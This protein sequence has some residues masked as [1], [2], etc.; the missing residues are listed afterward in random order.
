MLGAVFGKLF[1][2][3]NLSAILELAPSRLHMT[4]LRLSL[5]RYAE[6]EL[7][8]ITEI[9]FPLRSET[10]QPVRLDGQFESVTISRH[11]IGIVRC[12]YDL[13]ARRNERFAPARRNDQHASM[14][15]GRNC[16]RMTQELLRFYSAGSNQLNKN[17]LPC[18]EA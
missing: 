11:P 7:T 2:R 3:R 12:A 13:I 8:F 4:L 1:K 9:I 6:C 16:W 17:S 5:K 15:G 18:G 14:G 10:P